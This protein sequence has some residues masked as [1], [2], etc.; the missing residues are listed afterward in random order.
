MSG[1]IPKLRTLFVGGPGRS[2]TTVVAQRLCELPQTVA[3]EG[4]ELKFFT[5][6]NGLLDLWHSL[7]EHYSPNRAIV[8]MRQFRQFT[9]QLIDGQFSQ[10]GLSSLA[11][12]DDWH[13]LFDNFT[14]TLLRHNHPEPIAATQFDA[15]V[16]TLVAN[17]QQMAM[18]HSGA[19]V[20][21]TFFVDNTPHTVLGAA[22]LTRILPDAAFL[23]VMRDPRSIAQSLR[24]M[25]WGPDNLEQCCS[26]VDSYCRAWE[27]CQADHAEANVDVRAIHIE[28]LAADPLGAGKMIEGWLGLPN[29]GR[30]FSYTDP[31]ALNGWVDRAAQQDLLLLNRRLAI[32]VDFFGYATEKIGFRPKGPS[33]LQPSEKSGSAAIEESVATAT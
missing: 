27:N 25:S 18:T 8:A 7:G 24:S 15:A 2:G 23:H 11:G 32:W 13:S 26:W 30:Y 21:P 5:E 22:F 9:R 16:R 14:A 10:L 17:L 31:S 20:E 19:D 12:A 4:V 6:K 28:D 29:A 3:F 1:T 33:G